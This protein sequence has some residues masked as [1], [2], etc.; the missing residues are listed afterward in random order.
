MARRRRSH[1]TRLSR[2]A[3]LYL[4]S[5]YGVE[6]SRRLGETQGLHSL[7]D[8]L[9]LN[10]PRPVQDEVEERQEQRRGDLFNIGLPDI[11]IPGTGI[12][13]TSPFEEA[14]EVAGNFMRG[15]Y[16]ALRY[17]PQ[18]IYETATALGEDL[19]GDKKG[20]LLFTNPVTAIPAGLAAIGAAAMK[21]KDSETYEKA[22]K[23][24]GESYS[25]QYGPFVEG[26]FGEGFRRLKEEPLGPV[27]DVATL[28]SGGAAGTARFGGALSRAGMSG[29]LVNRMVELG[30]TTGRAPIELSQ[31]GNIDRRN[32]SKYVQRQQKPTEGERVYHG[33]GEAF[34]GLPEIPQGRLGTYVSPDPAEASSYAPYGAEGSRV[35]QLNLN[36]DNMLDATTPQ[37]QSIIQDIIDEA[38]ANPHDD[39]LRTSE[40][41]IADQLRQS[42]TQRGYSSIKLSDANIVALKPDV[43]TS[44]YDNFS[45]KAP[46]PSDFAASAMPRRYSPSPFRKMRQKG[47]DRLLT[48]VDPETGVARYK[49]W[50]RKGPGER[51]IA[52]MLDW[53]NRRT[54]ARTHHLNQ[55]MEEQRRILSVTEAVAPLVARLTPLQLEALQLR[56][57]GIESAEELERAQAMW[58]RSLQGNAR[59]GRNVDDYREADR[60]IVEWRASPEYAQ[61]ILPKLMDPDEDML[62]AYR[63]Y[64]EE[65]ERNPELLG[66]DKGLELTEEMHVGRSY[67][68]KKAVNPN[69]SLDELVMEAAVRRE[70]DPNYIEPTYVPDILDTREFKKGK[71][72]SDE[73]GS[74]RKRKRTYTG[75]VWTGREVFANSE[76]DFL[77]DFSLDVFTSGTFR[78]DAETLLRSLSDRERYLTERGYGM[79]ALNDV[80]VRG[81]DGEPLEFK[82]PNEVKRQLGDGWEWVSPDPLYRFF[83]KEI[84][85]AQMTVDELTK[86]IDEAG[87]DA[88]HFDKTL[89]GMLLS[90][91]ENDAEMFQQELVGAMKPGGYAVPKE[92]ME[93]MRQIRQAQEPF[94]N[95]VGRLYARAMNYWRKYTL[96][97]MPRWYVNTAV[98]SAVLAAIR[99]VVNPATYYKALARN[100]AAKLPPG[101][102]L[103]RLALQELKE[104]GDR[105]PR[106]TAQRGYMLAQ[107]IED[108]FRRAQFIHN[109]KRQDRQ[110]M[111]EV[112][113]V[114]GGD[115][116]SRFFAEDEWLMR[117]LEDKDAVMASF[118]ELNRFAYN[119][120]LMGPME[121]KYVRAFV[122]F[123][124]WYKFISKFAWSLPLEYPGRANAIAKL[125]FIGEETQDELGLLP[126]WV[127]GTL[128]LNAQGDKEDLMYLPTF[129][130][131]PMSQIFNPADPR[132]NVGPVSGGQFSPL[133][134]AGLSEMGV[135]TFT[136][137]AAPV[138]PLTGVGQDF[139][140]ES[141]DLNDP[142]EPRLMNSVGDIARGRRF[143]GTLLRSFPQMRMLE[144]QLAGQQPVYPESL[145]WDTRPML[146]REESKRPPINFGIG[147]LQTLM[148]MS[149]ARVKHYNWKEQTPLLEERLGAAKEDLERQRKRYNKRLKANR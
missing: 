45:P 92:Y 131:N 113:D 38:G 132:M 130:L 28:L 112:G 82:D 9:E 74:M 75:R 65:V 33:T 143:L 117:V 146:V 59:E 36:P 8:T 39:P 85:V 35:M 83:R 114:L 133:I 88:S 134:Q 2:L 145:P 4:G 142:N 13:L 144:E 123:W 127:A 24:I 20:A 64:R 1:P 149:G 100:S 139:F 128:I 27:L 124:G 56:M 115:A 12:N 23:P 137:G 16:E 26:D 80:V 10:P 57:R 69:K 25:W 51:G 37:G 98:G 125:G 15:G 68:T 72:E 61:R 120:Q 97:L 106:N 58:E 66:G 34:E 87:E 108:Y 67:A 44:P 118:D 86:V 77:R 47:M 49:P 110:R 140:K 135:D 96:A 40:G 50:T 53:W 7:I 89:R 78:A 121:R 136:G 22:I 62:A 102:T 32:L 141:W 30:S 101:V 3:R 103:G 18:G 138:S 70:E 6:S 126:P 17:L 43:L 31:L 129:G 11:E 104:S 19:T 148:N 84:N 111:A 55:K 105:N 41:A 116:R 14:G 76:P 93:T 90:R 147:G 79:D 42:A 48:D 63:A 99:G 94:E 95:P 119:Y 60:A 122:P 5:S 107:R 81:P 109:L 46:D 21:G 29:P 71:M 52:D 73:F 91:L 54:A